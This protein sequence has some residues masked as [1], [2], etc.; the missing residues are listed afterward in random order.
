MVQ[1]GPLLNTKWS[2]IKIMSRQ[3]E[4]TGTVLGYLRHTRGEPLQTMK[5]SSGGQASYSTGFA[6]LGE[7]S[8][9]PSES[10]DQLALLREAAFDFNEFF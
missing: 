4:Q 6:P 3:Q 1:I 10:V 9:N 7:C 8:R 5:L 2:A